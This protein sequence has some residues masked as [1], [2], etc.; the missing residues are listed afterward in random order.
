MNRLLAIL[1][2]QAK[3]MEVVGQITVTKFVEMEIVVQSMDI[4]GRVR[5][6]VHMD[7]SHS[8]VDALV[9]MQQLHQPLQK[10]SQLMVVVDQRKVTRFVETEIVVPS[11]DTVDQEMHGV[12]PVVNQDSEHVM[13]AVQ[14]LLRPGTQLQH[15]RNH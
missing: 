1:L 8:L 2:S 15:L 7:V 6:I 11:G 5:N 13:V 9:G 3:K 12:V 14:H 10:I 4:V